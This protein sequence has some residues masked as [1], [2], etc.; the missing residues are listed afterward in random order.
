[1][2]ELCLDAAV[3]NG[4]LSR[5]AGEPVELIH[6]SRD[7]ADLWMV[8]PR[9]RSRLGSARWQAVRALPGSGIYSTASEAVA[10]WA[11]SVPPQGVGAP[12]GL[13]AALLARLAGGAVPAN[14]VLGH[15]ARQGFSKHQLD[16]AARRAGIVRTKTAMDGGW[17]WTLPPEDR[18]KVATEEAT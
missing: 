15:F 12:G 6:R 11:G 3:I 9:D 18:A 10:F 5:Q 1:M 13:A 4:V 17:R 2:T 7:G 8:V 16:R 14:V